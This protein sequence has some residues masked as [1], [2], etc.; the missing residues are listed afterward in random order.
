M[1]SPAFFTAYTPFNRS[2]TPFCGNR[3]MDRFNRM[4]NWMQPMDYYF[5]EY[6]GFQMR[7]HA[8]QMKIE[9]NG[10]FTYKVDVSGFRPEEVT[11][12][13]EGNEVV[14]TGEHF[15]KQIEGETVHRQFTRR[16]YIPEG[17]KKE[18]F[19][20]EFDI[21]GR[22]IYIT[23]KQTVEGKRPIPIDF[24]PVN[25]IKDTETNTK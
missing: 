23:A 13:I 7:D 12:E 15:N 11:V 6:M 17:I 24:N 3:W 4:D 8:A 25:K 2:M 20:C 18:T 5:D 14:V 16:V 22:S 21:N 9:P 1:F 19:K 10:D